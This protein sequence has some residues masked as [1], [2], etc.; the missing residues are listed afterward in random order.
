MPILPCSIPLCDAEV[1]NKKRGL[2]SRHYQQWY[3]R[4]ARKFASP[5]PSKQGVVPAFTC[6][7][8]GLRHEETTS[9]AKR[10]QPARKFCNSTCNARHESSMRSR[11]RLAQKLANPRS[12]QVC[13]I[14][15]TM[16]K[17]GAKY[18]S[19]FCSA[20]WHGQRMPNS[21]PDK[22]CALEG[23]GR[24][25]TPKNK[26][27]KCCCENHGQIHYNRMSRASGRQASAPWD[28]RRRANYH[29]RRALKLQLPAD[30]I[31]P[32]DVYERDEWICGLCSE[33][34]DRRASYPDPMSA[35]L[36]HILPLSKGGHHTLS[37]VQ[38]AHLACNVRK[39]AS[40]EVDAM[41]TS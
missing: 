28:E 6:E 39:G 18:C 15:I 12:C 20:V 7:W 4:E 5:R 35:S 36:D 26:R 30:T 16:R 37:N 24:I 14:D 33:P 17:V 34:V 22:A 25:F 21:L 19:D 10:K 3:Y 23:C 38:L 27:Q 13:G 8:C 2:C 32:L 41:S 1:S 9:T 11:D 31:R 40:H 29:K